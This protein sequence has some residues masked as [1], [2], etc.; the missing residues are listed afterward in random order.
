MKDRF[1]FYDSLAGYWPLS[2]ASG[3]P[4]NCLTSGAG[5]LFE[6]NGTVGTAAGKI[7]AICASFTGTGTA[8]LQSSPTNFPFTVSGA[9]FTIGGWF[10]PNTSGAARLMGG[11][12][13]DDAVLKEWRINVNAGGAVVWS[14]HHSAIAGS[15]AGGD[16]TPLP[17]PTTG[18]WN[19]AT[20]GFDPELSKIITSGLAI[21]VLGGRYGW[22]M[23]N[24]QFSR[25]LFY[26]PDNAPA[27]AVNSLPLFFGF[28]P[29]FNG[30][31]GRMNGWF[32]YRRL[33]SEREVLRWW[34]GGQGQQ[35]VRPPNFD[36]NEAVPV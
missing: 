32:L 24:G 33:L 35:F 7:D 25:Q 4:R 29:S 18:A 28:L 14:C 17:L 23:L 34:N 21:S 12:S 13:S 26:S 27:I 5:R 20:F 3:Q 36:F 10:Y 22:T 16:S 19:F 9:A 11:R 31:D 1:S 8:Y 30:F 15:V 2:E 6:T